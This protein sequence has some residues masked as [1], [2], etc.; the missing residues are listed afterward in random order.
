MEEKNI[1]AKKG[2]SCH[3]MTN[4]ITDN[5]I[6]LVENFPHIVLPSSEN[7]LDPFLPSATNLSQPGCQYTPEAIV[8]SNNSIRLALTCSEFH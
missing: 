1:E 4:S 8:L 3:E 5:R 7:K 2:I 6:L